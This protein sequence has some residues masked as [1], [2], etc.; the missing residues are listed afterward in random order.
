MHACGHDG[1]WRFSLLRK[2]L[3]EEN[4]FGT[5]HLIFQPGEEGGAGGKAMIDDGLFKTPLFGDI[6]F[7]YWPGLPEGTFGLNPLDLW[8][9][10]IN[11][12]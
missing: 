4:F 1:H 11:L 5:L 2:K 3:A 8:L 9:Q 10:V 7:A 6:C 12:I